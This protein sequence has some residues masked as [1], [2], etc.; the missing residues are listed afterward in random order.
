MIGPEDYPDIDYTSDETFLVHWY[1]FIDHES[2]IKLYRIGLAVRCLSKSELY[3]MNDD[4]ID[5]SFAEVLYPENTLRLSANFTGR[6]YVSIIALNNAMEPSDVVCSDGISVDASPSKLHDIS[7]DNAKWSE[8]IYCDEN[9]TWLLLSDLTKVKLANTEDCGR[10]CNLTT[11]WPLI[12]GLPTII[13]N[14]G[15]VI[16]VHNGTLE[17]N[18]IVNSKNINASS[19][20]LC[21]TFPMYDSSMPIYLPNDR[22]TL[23]WDVQEEISQIEDIYVG[24]GTNPSEKDAPGI[25]GY[26]PTNK[27]TT[28]HINHA[29]IGTDKEFF[30]FLKPVNKAGLQIIIPIG[31]VLIDQTPPRFKSIPEVMIDNGE[32]IVGWENDTFYDDEQT[33]QISRIVFQI[34]NQIFVQSAFIICTTI[35]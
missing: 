13:S 27:K 11:F 5:S 32:I 28:F 19:N 6:R 18:N 10:K 8:S 31:P 29:G 26:I 35:H 9:T 15:N 14:T 2:G 22:I 1:G 20:I 24:I 12:D 33:S 16:T 34:G 7:L 30:L 25:I 4:L 23:R 21:S 17:L 3:Q